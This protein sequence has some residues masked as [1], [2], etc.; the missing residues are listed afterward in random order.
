[1]FNSTSFGDLTQGRTIQFN[2]F[3]GG[4]KSELLFYIFLNF[5]YA[6]AVG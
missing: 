1:M 5:M 4:G 6:L 2:N 3:H